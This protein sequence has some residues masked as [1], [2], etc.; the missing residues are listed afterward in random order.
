MFKNHTRILELTSK[1]H[2][3]IESGD[4]AKVEEMIK[5][6]PELD[7]NGEMT[8][9]PPIL[10]AAFA[11]DWKMFSV[12]FEQE[13]D[14]DVKNMPLKWYLIHECIANAPTNIAKSVINYANVNAQTADGETPLMIAIKKEKTVLAHYLIDSD[15]LN[16]TMLDKN[17]DTALHYAAKHNNQDLFLKLLDKSQGILRKNKQGKNPLDLLEDEIF[18]NNLPAYMEKLQ[19]ELK[20]V[21][22]PTAINSQPST[23]SSVVELPKEEQAPVVPKVTGLSSIKK[24]LK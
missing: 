19:K 15:R 13:A 22:K 17:H 8:T 5:E 9:I 23:V 21:N 16:L 11:E 1:F 14:L 10:F 7:I 18:K 6:Y 2:K 4:S 24:K 12:L 3:F 20:E